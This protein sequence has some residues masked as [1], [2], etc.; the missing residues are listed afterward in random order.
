MEGVD[1]EESLVKILSDSGGL[2]LLAETGEFALDNILQEGLLHDIPLLGTV[3][4]LVQAGLGLKGYLFMRKLSKFAKVART[5]TSDEER[6]KFSSLLEADSSYR[7]RV[8]ESLLIFL[9]RLDD[10]DKPELLAHAYSSLVKGEI[11]FTEFRRLAFAIDR[12]FTSDLRY[13]QTRQSADWPPDAASSL[14]GAG[15]VEIST[16]S[17]FSSEQQHNQYRMT[18]IGTLFIKIVLSR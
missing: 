9:E 6:I 1:P 10:L 14:S 3:I 5:G 4:K 7:K 17:R 11:E 12:C 13:L 15:L 2:D 16:A 8:G 18:P